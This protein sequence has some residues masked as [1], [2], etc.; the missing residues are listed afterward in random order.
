MGLG[1]RLMNCSIKFPEIHCFACIV[2]QQTESSLDEGFQLVNVRYNYIELSFPSPR[3]FATID[4]I[5][6]IQVPS[7]IN[8]TRMLSLAIYLTSVKCAV[9]AL[10]LHSDRILLHQKHAV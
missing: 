9:L 6:M 4:P 10:L 3:R 1:D 7:S 5:G 8:P 2:I